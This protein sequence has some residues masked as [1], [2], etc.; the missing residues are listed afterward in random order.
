MAIALRALLY[1]QICHID[2]SASRWRL[3][4]ASCEARL[5]RIPPLTPL[6]LRWSFLAIVRD[7]S[8]YFY[9]SA[10]NH[11]LRDSTKCFTNKHL[12]WAPTNY[13]YK[14]DWCSRFSCQLLDV[15]VA[16]CAKPSYRASYSTHWY[17]RHVATQFSH[18]S[19][20][21]LLASNQDCFIQGGRYN[22]PHCCHCLA[23]APSV[24]RCSQ[25]HW[26]SPASDSASALRTG[27][28]SSPV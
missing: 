18:F 14:K 22:W 7:A 19:S 13:C 1:S 28:A 27:S 26:W 9:R 5:H 4:L 25:A 23:F 6:S 20:P 15:D 17:Y 2:L 24:S 16:R 21:L 11:L 8:I 3:G 10:T 12:S